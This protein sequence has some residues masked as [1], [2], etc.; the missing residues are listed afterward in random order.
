[1]AAPLAQPTQV[2]AAPKAVAEAGRRGERRQ[3]S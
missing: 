1:M 3:A 2:K